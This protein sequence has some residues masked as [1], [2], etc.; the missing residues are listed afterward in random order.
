MNGRIYIQSLAFPSFVSF[1]NESGHEN[2]ML[3][4]SI[5]HNQASPSCFKSQASLGRGSW[6]LS[7]NLW[8]TSAMGIINKIKLVLA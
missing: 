8:M 4:S 1:F 2:V 7:F 6:I 3:E 5:R